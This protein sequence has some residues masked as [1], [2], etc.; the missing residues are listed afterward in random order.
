MTNG[1]DCQLCLDAIFQRAFEPVRITFQHG[2][3]ET[4][5]L[6]EENVLRILRLTVVLKPW[7]ASQGVV[8]ARKYDRPLVGKYVQA[9]IF[10]LACTG[11]K[12]GPREAVPMLEQCADALNVR[13]LRVHMGLGEN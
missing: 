10:V 1:V 4:L 13:S 2:L 9:D 8:P 3:Q 12:N 5:G 6:S 11:I 7:R